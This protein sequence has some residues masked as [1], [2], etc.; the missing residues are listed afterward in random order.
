MF[1]W[2][3]N[4]LYALPF[5]LKAADAEIASSKDISEGEGTTIEKEVN[6]NSVMHSLLKGEVTQ[7]VEEF[8]YSTNEIGAK[9]NEYEYIGNGQAVK[10]EVKKK[11]GKIHFFQSNKPV[12]STVLEDMKH[13]DD[14]GDLEQYFINL[15][16]S[17]FSRFRI[18]SFITE[19][20][21]IIKNDSVRTKLYFSTLPDPYNAASAAFINELKRIAIAKDSEYAL[22]RNEI[23]NKIST[24]SF[25]TFKAS[26]DEPDLM[27]YA[28]YTPKFIDYVEDQTSAYI[29]YEWDGYVRD[30]L[31][32]K[33]YSKSQDEKYKTKAKKEHSS[34][35]TFVD[36]DKA[37]GNFNRDV[38]KQIQEELKKRYKND[39][40]SN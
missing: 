3:K 14:Y 4:I 28:V 30:N 20:E 36:P 5:G 2:I 39:K 21:V 13:I 25:V 27:S 11:E 8:R 17:E 31:R 37:I 24:L 16:Y 22:N 6:E 29:E 10:K 40:S 9:A 34:Y 26:N 15:E 18:N 1:K 12:V 38:I 23:A 19:V 7:E 32:D 33:F 35:E